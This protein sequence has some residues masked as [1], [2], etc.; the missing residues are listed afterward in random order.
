MEA[1]LLLVGLAAGAAA[2][3]LLL[4]RR[5]ASLGAELRAEQERRVAAEHETVRLA[6]ELDAERRAAAERASVQAQLEATLKALQ[7]DLQKEAR[8]DLESR[9]RALAREMA[10]LKESLEKVTTSMQELEKARSASHGALSAQI[11][12]LVEAQSRLQ[13]ETANLA[14]AMRTTG[15]R[16]R[17]GEVQLRRIV[18]LAGMTAYCDFVEQQTVSA[19]GRTMR[20]DLVVRLSGGRNVVID[21]KVPFDAYMAASTAQDDEARRSL[22]REHAKAIRGHVGQLS[23]KA[24]WEPFEPTPGF[25]VLFVPAEALFHAALEHD[26]ALIEDAMRQGVV[27]ASPATL[28]ALLRTVAE[29]WREE[30]I[31]ENARKVSELGKQLYDRLS[32]LAGHFV[33][34]RRGLEGAVVAYND[35]VGSLERNVLVSARRFPELGVPA[36]KEIVEVEPIQQATRVVQAPELS[37][38]PASPAPRDPPALDLDGGGDVADAA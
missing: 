12:D 7:A 38:R 25:V 23:A 13:A 18:E 37:V 22:L 34:L 8:E 29:G 32:V 3:W 11:R 24:Y 20:P 1:L 10:P 21:A 2:L 19:E 4:G 30:R 35:A 26:P 31:A 27:I 33:K 36:S 5:A 15:V 28:I 9:Q 16:G 17:W 14:G 6:A